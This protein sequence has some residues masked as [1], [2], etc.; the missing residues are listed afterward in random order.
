[1]AG[2]TA[3]QV[4]FFK[5]FGYVVLKNALSSA[6]M[7]TLNVE[8][9]RTM[10]AQY[11][12]K[13]FDGTARYWSTLM[14]EDTPLFASLLEDPRFM[15]SGQQMYGDDV[16]G[17]TVDG[18]RYV[19]NTGWHPDSRSNLLAGVKFA[20]YMQ[21]V[22]AETGA[23]RVIPGSHRLPLE[24][25][26]EFSAGVHRLSITDVPAQVL[27]SEPGD[28]VGFDLRLWH[29][30]FGGSSDRRMCTVVY[31]N[32]PKTAEEKAYFKRGAEQNV[33]VNIKDF[34]PKRRHLFSQYWL[35][36]RSANPDRQRFINRMREL[37]SFD[38]PG[39]VEV[40]EARV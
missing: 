22:G 12:H 21:P 31:Y 1:M 2:L 28:V 27:A 9:D 23:L 13:P 35:E 16:L 40:A 14:E 24:Q 7:R 37:G 10:E 38:F 11:A 36:N 39:V 34:H 25:N 15:R 32:N 18:N 29:A 17:I 3:A 30:S 8:F 26:E 19:G 5:T 20:I 4:S 33:T 6:E